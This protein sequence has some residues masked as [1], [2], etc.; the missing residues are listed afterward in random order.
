MTQTSAHRVS[1]RHH[2]RCGC[3]GCCGSCGVSRGGHVRVAESLMKCRCGRALA[4]ALAPESRGTAFSRLTALPP[5][6]LKASRH[7]LAS[8]ARARLPP[9]SPILSP[10]VLPRRAFSRRRADG[11]SPRRARAP[12]DRGREMRRRAERRACVSRG[13]APGTTRIV[14][15]LQASGPQRG[16]RRFESSPHAVTGALSRRV[17]PL[18][19]RSEAKTTIRD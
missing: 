15:R 3:C 12:N 7:I 19:R 8:P 1:S 5:A 10:G 13:S 6:L 2:W 16:A 11:R 4:P 17:R 9:F 14:V 18:N